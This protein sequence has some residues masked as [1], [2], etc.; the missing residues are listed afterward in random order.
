MWNGYIC[1][2]LGGL[3]DSILSFF[4]NHNYKIY[5]KIQYI[6]FE[7]T[8][9]L[10][11]ESFSLLRKNHFPLVEK[12]QISIIKESIYDL[13]DLNIEDPCYILAFDFLDAIAHDHV[14]FNENFKKNFDQ[15]IQD[16]VNQHSRLFE[17]NNLESNQEIMKNFNL[18]LE[19]NFYSHNMIEQYCLKYSAD[20]FKHFKNSKYEMIKSQIN[21]ENTKNI[22]GYQL[23][24]QELKDLILDQEF[25]DFERKKLRKLEDRFIRLS[26]RFYNYFFNNNTMWVPSRAIKFL[27][28]IDTNFPNHHLIIHD[29]DYLPVNMF[30]KYKGKNAPIVYSLHETDTN[31]TVFKDLIH[32][33]GK[34]NV[35]FP[36]DFDLIQFIY[37]MRYNK[38][39]SIKN[40]SNFMSEYSLNEW[41][42]TRLGFNPMV[43]T[44]KNTKF[45][46]TLN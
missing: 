29:F 16:F 3:A 46:I 36:V 14:C 35:Y 22:L 37:K 12:N 27:D 7:I 4:K 2:N 9:N 43:E 34:A 38:R 41:G 17:R 5:K 28:S 45:L 15:Q 40:F 26:K 32:P 44:H 20:M 42:L 24:P 39:S 18:F 30:V 21:D 25:V 11:D 10:I 1:F 31:I 13:K 19:R 8:E 23:F 33:P 6:S